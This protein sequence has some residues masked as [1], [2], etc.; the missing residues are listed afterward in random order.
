M[1]LFIYLFIIC[2]ING[3]HG[4]VFNVYKHQL[5]INIIHCLLSTVVESISE[6]PIGR[7]SEHDGPGTG[8]REDRQAAIG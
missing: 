5:K 4:N 1:Y 7:H 2:R 8:D 6:D 3:C